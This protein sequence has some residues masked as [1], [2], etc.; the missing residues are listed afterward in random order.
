M[1]EE[2]IQTQ[3]KVDVYTLQR[4]SYYIVKRQHPDNPTH[5]IWDV[6]YLSTYRVWWAA[7]SSNQI[8]DIVEVRER[9]ELPDDSDS[10]TGA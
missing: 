3:P 8:R 5:Q 9:V 4:E 6:C 10:H 2:S 1:T 7:G